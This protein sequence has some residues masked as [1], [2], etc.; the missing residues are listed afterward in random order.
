M[1][2]DVSE[3][4]AAMMMEV[5]RTCETSVDIYLTTW[6]YIPEDSE[7]CNLICLLLFFTLFPF[8]IYLLHQLVVIRNVASD[9]RR[10]AL[11]IILTRAGLDLDP[12]ALK[13]LRVTVPKLGLV[14]WLVECVV[15]AVM[16]HYLM[17]LPWIWGFLLGYVYPM[18]KCTVR[19]NYTH[20]CISL[21]M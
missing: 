1:S 12:A 2:T 15:V 16:T 21:Q 6:Q 4:H 10:V 9:C 5:A 7:L 13:R 17:D 3:V 18:I 11:V 19:E 20:I 8:S 14:P